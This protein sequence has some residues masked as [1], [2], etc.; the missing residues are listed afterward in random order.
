M[1]HNPTTSEA[2]GSNADRLDLVKLRDSLDL[3]TYKFD[4]KYGGESR[5]VIQQQAI[6][7]LLARR[8][9]PAPSGLAA[10]AEKMAAALEDNASGLVYVRCR[11][12]K[13]SGVGF[14]RARDKA[15]QALAA[16]RS[17]TGEP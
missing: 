3:P 13:L 10:A 15:D 8:S 14:D 4:A 7:Y 5:S 2:A 6:R 11:Y 16:Y 9:Q 17:V 1:I 12:G